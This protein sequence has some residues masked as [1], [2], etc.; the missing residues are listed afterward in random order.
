MSAINFEHPGVKVTEAIRGA[1]P[2]DRLGFKTGKFVGT[3]LRGP[4]NTPTLITKQ[5]QYHDIFG[6]RNDVSYLDDAIRAWFENVDTPAYV[7][8]VIGAA[9]VKATKTLNDAGVKQVETATVVAAGGITQNGTLVAT[10]TAVGLNGSPKAVN[11]N[12]LN[13]DTAA[14]AATKVR[15]ALAADADVSA[16]ADVSGAGVD[17]VLTK[18]T[19]AANDATLNIA[20]ANGTAT[21]LTAAPNSANTTAGVAPVATLKIDAMGPGTDYNYVANP[22]H[23]VSVLYTD[24]VLEVYDAGVL[25]ERYR[26]VVYTN[27]IKSRDFINGSSS[28]VQVTWLDTTVNPA[29]TA[30]VGGLLTGTDGGAI[31]DATF[32]GSEAANPKTGIYAFAEKTLPL[33]Y[34]MCPGQSGVTVGMALI[35]VAERFRQ[36]AI[37]D[38]TFG[39]STAQA[40]VEVGQFSA[41]QGHAVY[42]YGWVQVADTDTG[43]LKWVPRSPLR[44]AH[45]ARSHFQPG[46]IANV[47]AGVDYRLR[48]VLALE[49]TVDDL[50]QGELNRNR[51]DVARNFSHEGWGI[52]H[53]AARTTSALTLYRFLQVR[54]IFNV[55]AESI[56]IGLKPYVF[57]PI[58]GK[59]RL[60]AE[61]KSSIEGLLWDLWDADVLFGENAD[62]AFLVKVDMANLNQLEAGVL[63]VEVYCKPTP[64][65]ERINVTLFRVPLNFDMKTGRVK[66]GNI[67]EAA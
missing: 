32:V 5:S 53:W 46:S 31:T 26:D 61:I 60:A 11:V 37:I 35:D 62:D 9:A 58:D 40:I 63:N 55:I 56:E 51:I 21:G 15:A 27:A 24:G 54:V 19:A 52:I 13:G 14:Q 36:L 7:V 8:R 48:N 18:K 66:V 47:G 34:I 39:Y 22:A 41:A 23:G 44:A 65:A 28:L 3:A 45:I 43:A 59:G 12:V 10:V 38:S 57:R 20:L 1:I 17:V 42:C 64:I 6:P 2:I 29:N 33:G 30:A 49:K 16:F 67:E 25:K 50:T 4:V